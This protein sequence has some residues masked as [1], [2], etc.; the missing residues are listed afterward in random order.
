MVMQAK[1][2]GFETDDAENILLETDWWVIAFHSPAVNLNHHRS[3]ST[4]ELGSKVAE[5][6]TLLQNAGA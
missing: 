2:L 3:S 5:L 6:V 4:N 1:D